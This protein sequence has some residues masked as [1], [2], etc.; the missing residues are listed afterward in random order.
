MVLSR[1]LEFLEAHAGRNVNGH[2]D[3]EENSKY[4]TNIAYQ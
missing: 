3:H 4:M 1:L 2:L